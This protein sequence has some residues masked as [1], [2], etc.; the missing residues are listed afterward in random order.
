MDSSSC[1]IC[2][3]ACCT[4]SVACS[5]AQHNHLVFALHF[6]DGSLRNQHGVFFSAD[7]DSHPAESARPQERA[8]ILEFGR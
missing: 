7:L 6:I 4:R 1:V 8:F 3:C 2:A 5:G